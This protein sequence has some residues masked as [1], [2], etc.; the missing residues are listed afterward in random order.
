MLKQRHHEL[1][2]ALPTTASTDINLNH[3]S[4]SKGKGNAIA[5]SLAAPRSR[6]SASSAPADGS[7]GQ[8]GSEDEIPPPPAC[9]TLCRRGGRAPR[10][11]ADIQDPAAAETGGTSQNTNTTVTTTWRHQPRRRWTLYGIIDENEEDDL[12]LI[13]WRPTKNGTR[14]WANSWQK[15]SFANAKAVRDWNRPKGSRA[16]REYV[17]GVS[18][19]D[20]V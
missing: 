19:V 5:Q 10:S 9:R 15:R 14:T 2:A 20:Y 18:E 13:V 16:M 8:E 1:R 4:R 11:A 12:Y 3:A 6:H 7:G 17:D